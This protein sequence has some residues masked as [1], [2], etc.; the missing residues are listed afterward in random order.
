M[1]IVSVNIARAAPLGDGVKTPTGIAKQPRTGP[2]PVHRL[3]L[4]NDAICN[5]KHHGGED[6]AVYLY[7]VEDYAWWSERL[8]RELLPGTFGENLTVAGIESAGIGIGD[9]FVIDDLVLETT[10]PRIPCNTLNRRMRDPRFGIA[11]R[12]ALRPG[13]YCRVIAESS[14]EK[15]ARVQH[16]PSNGVRITIAEMMEDYYARPLPP[17]RARQYL[18]TPMSNKMR[19]EMQQAAAR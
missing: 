15:D 10:S 7:S 4:A 6:Q 8:E 16:E 17:D 13:W 18:E 14:I 12:R 5:L 3:G 19:P 9:R 11:F 2:V 1:H